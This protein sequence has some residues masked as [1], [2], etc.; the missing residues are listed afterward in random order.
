MSQQHGPGS[1]GTWLTGQTRPK[2]MRWASAL[3]AVLCGLVLG[4]GIAWS[5]SS[6]GLL[7]SIN[8]DTASSSPASSPSESGL[9]TPVIDPTGSGGPGEPSVEPTAEPTVAPPPEPV[10]FYIATAGDVL[11]HTPVHVSARKGAG[12]DF[13]PLLKKINPL[14]KASALALCHMEVPLVPEGTPVSGYPQFAASAHIATDLAQQGWDGCSTASNHSVDKG[15][16]GIETTLDALD[17]AGLGFTG[18]ARSESEAEQIQFYTVQQNG[19]DTLIAHLSV[20]RA[21][22]GLPV[23]AEKPW[24]VNLIDSDWVIEQARAARALGADIV[25]A[26]VHDGV[27]YTPNPTA[28]QRAFAQELADSGEI[29]LY[30]GHHP[31]VPQPIE[32]LDGGPRGDG[33]W[34]AFSHGNFLSNQSSACCVAQTSNGLMM[35]THIETDQTE[36]PYVSEVAWRALTVDRAGKHTVYDLSALYAKGKGAGT[37]SAADVKVRYEQVRAVVGDEAPELD[38]LPVFD[39]TVAVSRKE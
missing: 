18:T 26:S 6:L 20:T 36:A 30:V 38:E 1:S 37:L 24:S 22:N 11:L 34:T 33:M 39:G 13:T 10:S 7:H 28:E 29:D 12:Y 2:K 9:G 15:F 23:P 17:D 5:L 27:E 3:L 16:S 4:G 14:V 21:L 25:I 19:Y 31:H 8:D 35:F 32:K